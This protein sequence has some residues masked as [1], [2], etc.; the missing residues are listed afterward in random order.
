MIQTDLNA[1]TWKPLDERCYKLWVGPL[2][3]RELIVFFT[4]FE[5][6]FWQLV[7]EDGK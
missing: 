1:R 7:R 5:G 4:G 2:P 3:Y 6:P